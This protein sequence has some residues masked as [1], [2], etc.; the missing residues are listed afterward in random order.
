MIP[1][2]PKKYIVSKTNKQG[3]IEYGNDCFAEVS[4]Y[5]EAG[6]MGQSHNIIRHPDMPKLIFKMMWERVL[7]GQN[8]FA[9]VKNL[10]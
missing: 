9:V 6:L 8:I 4:A 2:S 3:F 10:A 5:T 1:L 7:R